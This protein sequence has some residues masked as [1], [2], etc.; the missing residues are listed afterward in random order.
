MSRRG[1]V[2]SGVVLAIAVVAVACAGAGTTAPGLVRELGD[3]GDSTSTSVERTAAAAAPQAPP[4]TAAPEPPPPPPPPPKPVPAPGIAVY[5][6]LGTWVD[7][8]DWSV[9]FSKQDPPPIGVAEVDAMA[10]AGVQTLFIQTAKWDAPGDVLEPERLI[11]IVERARAHGLA[12]VGWYLPSLMD[13]P[14]DLRKLLATAGLGL[15]GLA[16][17]IESRKLADLAERNRRLIALS[18]ELRRALPGKV[19]GAIPYPPVLLDVVNPNLWPS[20]PWRE[21]APHYDVWLPMNYQS[22]R[23]SAS[24]YRDGYRYTAENIDRMRIHLGWLDAPV[25]PIGGI[26]DQTGAGDVSGMIRAATERGALGGS[27]YDWRTTNPQL[28]PHLHGFRASR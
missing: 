2:L 11:P 25:H 26:A 27:L 21:L 28:W 14:A 15:D 20:F 19:I 1:W 3:R 13:P 5:R 8:Y 6:G 7:V 24:G 12:V 4:T 9:T 18:A 10:G 22:F 16:V 23:A 17:D